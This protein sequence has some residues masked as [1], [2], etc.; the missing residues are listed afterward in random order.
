MGGL[1]AA[2]LLVRAAPGLDGELLGRRLGAAWLVV[3]GGS[4][5]LQARVLAHVRAHIAP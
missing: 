4:E 5:A 1:R 2:A 3:E